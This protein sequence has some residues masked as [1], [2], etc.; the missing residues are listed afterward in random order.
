MSWFYFLQ[1][2]LAFP[3]IAYIALIEIGKGEI[4]KK[5]NVKGLSTDDSNFERNFD[6][7]VEVEFDKYL[8]EFPVSKLEKIKA[9]KA[10]IEAIKLWKYWVKK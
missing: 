5:I 2:E 9:S 8:M 7:K 3:F 6:L 4:F 10:T 1:D